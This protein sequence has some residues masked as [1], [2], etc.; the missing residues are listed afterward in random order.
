[1][2]STLGRV[3]RWISSRTFSAPFPSLRLAWS[4]YD[5][6]SKQNKR[7]TQKSR[8]AWVGP[9]VKG[10][11]MRRRI[12]VLYLGTVRRLGLLLLA[13]RTEGIMNQGNVGNV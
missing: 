11:S 8:L 4:M 13:S 10:F 3:V 2:I 7:K 1:M 6:I 5:L 12:S 9:S